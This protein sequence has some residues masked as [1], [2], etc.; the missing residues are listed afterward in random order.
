VARK[1]QVVVP[2]NH[3]AWLLAGESD[4]PPRVYAADGTPQPL[5]ASGADLDTARRFVVLT[6]EGGR[7]VALA[8]A[9]GTEHARWHFVHDGSGW[10]ALLRLGGGAT[11]LQLNVW[12]LP[13]EEATL[14]REL[15]R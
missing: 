3:A 4:Q 6:G 14:L 8:V 1:F 2:A 13:R 10:K 7:A 15:M 11:E 5:S 12:G 9:A